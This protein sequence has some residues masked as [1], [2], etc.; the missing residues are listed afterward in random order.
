MPYEFSE[1]SFVVNPYTFAKGNRGVKRSEK[2]SEVGT[3][4]GVFT[5]HL[6][7]KT[8]LLIPDALEKQEIPG[9]KK[10]KQEIPGRKAKEIK[11]YSYP[12]FRLGE[13]PV[14]PGSSLRG[15]LRSMYEALTDS[16]YS[17]ARPEQ[18][19]TARPKKAF[20]PGLL[21]KDGD[22]WE[23]HSADR[24]LFQI[25]EYFRAL[26][27]PLDPGV[28]HSPYE[29][30]A[31]NYGKM[32]NFQGFQGHTAVRGRT[33]TQ[34][35]VK[36]I[37]TAGAT[38]T[39]YYYV[40][41]YISK[42]K[43]ESIFVMKEKINI[44]TSIIEKAFAPLKE[45]LKVY[46]NAKIN[47]KFVS[48]SVPWDSDQHKGYAH[49][50]LK[51]FEKEGGILP[52]WYKEISGQYYFSFASIGRFQYYTPID[53][54]LKK[55]GKMPCSSIK[56]LCKACSLFGMVGEEEGLGSSVRITDAVFKETEGT[57]LQE[58]PSYN[59]TELRTPHPSYL[60]FYAVTNDY[61]AGY[62]DKNCTIRGRKFYWHSKPKYKKLQKLS[63]D[64][65][66]AKMEGIGKNEGSFQFQVYFEKLSRE[67]VLELAVLLCLGEN[68]QQGN[69]CFKLGHGKPL[70]FGSAKIVVDKLE[71]RKFDSAQP[72]YTIKEYE[73][74]EELEEWEFLKDLFEKETWEDTLN[75]IRTNIE[76]MT[77]I[78]SFN[79]NA[80]GQNRAQVVYPNVLNR[81]NMPD[82]QLNENELASSQWFSLNWKF[83]SDKP[84]KILPRYEDE[85]ENQTLPSAEFRIA[86]RGGNQG[87]RRR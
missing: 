14:I 71:I 73:L 29:V 87:N 35:Y 11:H 4:T 2:E 54:I 65:I 25:E 3:H 86:Q 52:I 13:E 47:Q 23:L 34:F 26:G 81:T 80:D 64:K 63:G 10:E 24:Y 85:D 75:N 82:D 21:K 51:N 62:D 20:Q 79:F 72:M 43:Y 83:G 59:L 15:P 36:T 1:T 78:L 84:S 53:Q 18:Y 49:I 55:E 27:K 19:I 66:D 28:F 41:E 60:P 50:N 56:K 16:C 40:G 22:R 5:C 48:S 76:G 7:P 17:T 74:G 44:T 8:P 6:Y 30:A 38:N 31:A 33:I 70:G 61:L 57:V 58:I 42:K 45:T 69:Y 46:Q 12:F 32:V 68:Q 9:R 67:Q 37:G 77:K 39:G